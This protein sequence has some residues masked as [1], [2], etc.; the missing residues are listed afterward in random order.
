[1]KKTIQV[2]LAT[3][4][5]VSSAQAV[6]S[7]KPAG[8]ERPNIIFFIA[9]DMYTDMFNC[10]PDGKGKN[11]TPNMDRLARE[12]TVLMNQYVCSPV[13]T[14]SRYNCLT[15]Q[16]ASRSKSRNFLKKAANEGG[17]TVIQ[18]NTF[19]SAGQ[20]ALPQILR[21]AGYKTGMVGKNHVIEVQ[22]LEDFE[23]YWD[24]PHKPENI[25]RLESN[26]KKT[27]DGMKAAG[28]DYAA[29]IYYDNPR[30]VGL[31]DLAKQNMEWITEGGVNFIDQN[32]DDP[33]FLYF[34]TTI[35]HQP[36]DPEHSWK[37]D[38]LVSAKGYLDKVPDSGMPP[39]DT[40]T[41][42]LKEAGI[43]GYNKE[44]VLW[45]DDALGALMNRLEKHG[46]LDNTIIFFF[47]DHGQRAKGHLYQ[48]GIWNPS[49][50]WRSKGFKCGTV[51]DTKIQNIDF[52]PTILDFA[53]AKT[54][55]PEFDGKSFRPV[56]EGKADK[57]HDT[58]FFELGYAR[59][60]IKGDYKYMAIRYPQVLANRTLKERT[61]VLEAYNETRV[62]MK[63][64]PVNYD[65]AAPYSHFSTVPG[66]EQAEH[67]SYGKLPGYFDP[68]Q[69]YD[70]KKDPTE[71]KNLA[72][73][74]EYKAVLREM[75]GELQKYLAGLPGTF[76]L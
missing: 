6:S 43:K 28:F 21:D 15:G 9:D 48:G 38:P 60:V 34:A 49:I 22:G 2:V 18:W 27:I 75:K 3:V 70:L 56:L 10:L 39:R 57:I 12:G 47:N 51:C 1:M 44:L 11:L 19:I 69:L 14:P 73:A 25:A 65:P 54:D 53:G 50:I 20:K 26:Y 66:G 32:K 17:Q 41:P 40:L 16:Y 31:G 35:P 45:L 59:G 33:F 23:D 64:E 76:D 8:K 74:P 36:S 52:A 58:L 62:R 5:I 46:L 7:N 67:E 68:D 29:S 61:K 42:R 30:F 24:D 71:Q 63:T 37:A 55:M 13:C 72:N 4:L